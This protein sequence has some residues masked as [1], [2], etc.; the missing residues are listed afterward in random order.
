MSQLTQSQAGHAHVLHREA[1]SW[2][3]SGMLWAHFKPEAFQACM[4]DSGRNLVGAGN[5]QESP[6]LPIS[7]KNTEQDW[8]ALAWVLGILVVGCETCL[9][10]FKTFNI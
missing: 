5:Q 6:P 2:M 3:P 7:L 9:S 8:G 10:I 4:R 1:S